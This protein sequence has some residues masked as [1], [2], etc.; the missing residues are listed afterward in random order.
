MANILE[1][2][3]RKFGKRIRITAQLIEASTGFHLWSKKYD[4]DLVDIFQIQDEIGLEIANQLQ[5]TLLG[6]TVAPKTREQ[7]RDVEAF[8][9]YC[10]GR[11]LYYKR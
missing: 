7:T 2:S 11:S 4:R 5:V 9:L 6:K 1:G 3:V 8:Q 10:K